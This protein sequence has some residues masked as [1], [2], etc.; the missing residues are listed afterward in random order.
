MIGTNNQYILACKTYE[1]GVEALKM[2][3]F[4]IDIVN[5]STV[6]G[7]K[8]SAMY[9]RDVFATLANL[10]AADVNRY[11]FY[12]KSDNSSKSQDIPAVEYLYYGGYGIA[13]LTWVYPN[14]ALQAKKSWSITS[15]GFW[16]RN[17]LGWFLHILDT[18]MQ[19]AGPYEMVYSFLRT[20]DILHTG[21]SQ[22][23]QTDI[24]VPRSGTCGGQILPFTQ[25]ANFFS[26]PAHG[27]VFPMVSSSRAE[28]VTLYVYKCTNITR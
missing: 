18:K 27:I 20:G 9:T 13:A 24:L 4:S 2:V 19:A 17:P 10:T 23:N 26:G 22:T 25:N 1:D 14:N 15:M 11:F 3:K 5:Q 7:A 8:L 28:H 21:G 6:V 12:N 16:D